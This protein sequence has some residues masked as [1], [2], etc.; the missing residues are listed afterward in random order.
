MSVIAY[1]CIT[2]VSGAVSW[3]SLI[4]TARVLDAVAQGS[5]PAATVALLVMLSA[6]GFGGILSSLAPYF[7][8]RWAAALDESLSRLLLTAGGAA[9]LDDFE[10]PEYY[11]RLSKA[12]SSGM[13]NLAEGLDSVVLFSLQAITLAANLLAI[14]GMAGLWVFALCAGGMVLGIASGGTYG[15]VA[16]SAME[17]KVPGRRRLEYLMGEL[18]NRNALAELKLWD[19]SGWFIRQLNAVNRDLLRLGQVHRWRQLREY[20]AVGAM[21]QLLYALAILVAV[22]LHLEGALTLGALATLFIALRA[23]VANAAGCTWRW[24]EVVEWS[25]GIG[26]LAAFAGSYP[27]DGDTDPARP[28]PV[29][30]AGSLYAREVCF[31]YPQA[32]AP[33]LDQITLGV[34]AGEKVALVGPNGSGKSTLVKVLLGLYRPTKGKV[35]PDLSAG[36]LPRAAV[37]FQDMQRYQLTLRENVAM[38]WLPALHDDAA[39]KQALAWAGASFVHEL[40]AGLDTR[41]GKLVASHDLSAG[42]WQRVALARVAVSS[43]PFVF[44]DEPSHALDPLAELNLCRHLW[45]LVGDRAALIVTHRL[46]LALRADR[47]LVMEGGRVVE[48]GTHSELLAKRGRYFQMYQAQAVWYE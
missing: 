17:A 28:S 12:R 35:S 13:T 14:Q 8:S 25:L 40:P 1:L 4:Y 19:A 36:S 10:A 31:R 15:R 46:G 20:T 29:Q 23:L 21:E 45:E 30:P 37:A 18:M 7:S 24:A 5:L 47:V 39:I 44:F 9:R 34:G 27:A 11:E 32:S 43:A 38:G 16:S 22:H 2:A 33:A 41:L 26:Y 42:Q 6:Y 3:L 48:S